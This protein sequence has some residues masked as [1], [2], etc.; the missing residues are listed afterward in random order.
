LQG[1]GTTSLFG[2]G[3]VIGGV[4]NVLDDLTNP[5]T[6]KDPSKFLGSIIKGANLYGNTKGLSNQGIRQEGA[7]ILTGTLSRAAGVNVGVGSSIAGAVF[8][9]TIGNGQNQT[10]KATPYKR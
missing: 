5:N 2:V 4:G 1:G 7:N 6:Y 9:K 10:T 8:P 3:G